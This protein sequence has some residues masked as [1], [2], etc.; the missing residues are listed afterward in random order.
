M[1]NLIVQQAIPGI[2]GGMGTL[3]H[4]EFERRL[5]ETQTARGAYRDQQHPVW[6]LINATDVPDRTQSLLGK[7]N[8]CVPWLVRYGR[9]LEAAGADFLVVVCNTAH[10]FYDQVQPHLSIP[11]LHL[12]DLTS[13]FIAKTYPGLKTIGVLATDGTLGSKLF[14]TSL[15]KCGLTP[16]SF[17]LGSDLQ[18]FVTQSVYHPEWGI[19][20]TGS[21][22]SPQAMA[23]LNIA[24]T[25]LEHQGA[26]LIIAGCT[27]LS[28]AF[29]QTNRGH[30]PIVD[31]LN[32]L[33]TRT[34]DLAYG[35]CSLEALLRHSRPLACSHTSTVGIP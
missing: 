26:E 5:L 18:Q 32:V 2:L 9:R 12:T 31:P 30:C 22:V 35:K 17:E 13:Q 1:Q 14:E 23:A 6:I 20:S 34:L 28:V 29:R 3:A 19:K 24:M 4:L 15:L 8:S 16:L 21:Q 33:A 27:E 25:A 7:A 11:W 10:A